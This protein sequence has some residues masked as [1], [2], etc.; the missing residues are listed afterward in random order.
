[1]RAGA[2]A[3][4]AAA[5]ASLG[6]RADDAEA[7]KKKK[8]VCLNGQTKKVRNRKR[9][10][11]KNPTA[12]VGACVTPAQQCTTASPVSCDPN[13]NWCCPSTLPTCCPDASIAGFACNPANHVC[14][15]TDG[16]A[17]APTGEQCCQGGGPRSFQPGSYCA[18]TGLLCCPFES[19]VGACAAGDFCCPPIAGTDAEGGCCPAFEIVNGNGSEAFTGGCCNPD[20]EESCPEGW[21]CSTSGDVISGCCFPEEVNPV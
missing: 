15:G 7:K 8:P 17:C 18:P 11:K 16:A 9:F 1:M 13:G 5:L 14:C 20:D 6:L 4:A 3:L 12:T 19:E 2:G 10:L 21:R